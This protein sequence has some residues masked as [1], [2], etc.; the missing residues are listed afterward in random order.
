LT[1][2][3]IIRV[4][5]D[6]PFTARNLE[7]I[8]G[9]KIVW[10]DNLPDHLRLMRDDT[11]VAIY[12]HASFLEHQKKSPIFPDGFIEETIQTFCLLFPQF[13]R[14]SWKWFRAQQT[15]F[16]LDN[17]A[18][19]CGHLSTEERQIDNFVFWHDRIGIPKQAFDEAEPSTIAQ[20]WFD[21]RRRVQWYTFWV[22][23]LVLALTIFFGAIQCIDGGLQVYKA[24]YPS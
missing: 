18:G 13:D 24:Y 1:N 16:R 17:K 11:E 7:R 3:S 22:A 19:A 2:R 6:R 23:A 12:H 15:K 10:T 4:K 9:L 14:G 21:R 20:W 8:A 5:L